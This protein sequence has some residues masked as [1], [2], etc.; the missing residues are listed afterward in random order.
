MNQLAQ[1]NTPAVNAVGVI[2][3]YSTTGDGSAKIA[4]HDPRAIWQ[5]G[6]GRLVTRWFERDAYAVLNKAA[7]TAETGAA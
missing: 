3:A 2:V 4:Y 5:T 7:A 1:I 6:R